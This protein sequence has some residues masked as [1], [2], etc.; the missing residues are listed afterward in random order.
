MKIKYFLI[1]LLFL[2]Y[3]CT[4]PIKDVVHSISGETMGTTYSVKFISQSPV[5]LVE[6]ENEV[7][8]LLKIVNQQM[9]TFIPSSELSLL[10][11]SKSTDWIEVSYDLAFVMHAA[12]RISQFSNGKFDITIGPLVNLWGFGPDNK[13][14]IVPSNRE[15]KNLRTYVGYRNVDV[16]LN[17]PSIKKH[18]P[19]VYCDLSAIAKG[20]G[21]DK[22]SEY[23]TSKDINNYL[24]EIGGELRANGNK[25]KDNW[26]VGISVPTQSGTIQE[27][28]YLNNQS[29]ATSG[30]YWNYFEENGIRYSHTINPVT[31]KPITHKLASVTI[32]T[33]SCMEADA[34][35]T[36]ID[37]MGPKAGLKFAKENE[38]NVYFIVKGEN[39]FETFF[40][41]NFK[42]LISER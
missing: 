41:P 30:D 11:K 9:S 4:N 24:V 15:I 27:T 21:V 8:Y 19:N 33:E 29:M 32:I 12:L 36:A 38:L 34:L 28:I 10:N 18:N 7:N 13:P 14:Q 22:I 16:R 42:V 40:T 31:G 37:V 20:F 2:L 3:S 5:N 6:I 1:S 26:V 25:F 23:L 17:P 39:N 35:A